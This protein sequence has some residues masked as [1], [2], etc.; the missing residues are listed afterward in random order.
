MEQLLTE[1]AELRALVRDLQRRFA[2][3]AAVVV[4]VAVGVTR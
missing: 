1:V 4:E 3:L 2:E